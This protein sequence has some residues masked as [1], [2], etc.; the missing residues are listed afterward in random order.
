[1]RMVDHTLGEDM[2]RS[3]LRRFKYFLTLIGVRLPPGFLHQIQMVVNYMSLGR[4]MS[5]HGFYF[6]RVIDRTA[7]FESVAR[8][9]RDKKVLYLEFGVYAGASMRYWS[10][11]LHHPETKLQGFDSFEGLPEDFDTNGPY[12]KGTFDVGGVIPEIDDTRVKFFKGWFEDI[13]PTYSVP[14]HDVLVITM[15]ADLYS[16]TKYVLC[17]LRP[18][19]RA[20]TF[21]YFDD[22]SRPDHE[23]R[24]FDE[25]MQESGL[26][27]KPVCADLSL[28]NAFFQCVDSN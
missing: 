22:L 9:V 25:F 21:I 13:L 26:R 18:Y 8:Q 20:G 2:K 24:A 14:S 10:R 12:R 16:S 7:V 28:N 11:E 17:F 19:I 27:F 15:D 6:N 23:P 3:V 4:W 5:V 1:M